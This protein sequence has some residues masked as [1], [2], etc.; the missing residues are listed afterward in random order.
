MASKADFDAVEWQT[1]IEGPAL[2]G[3]LVI[4]SQRGGTIRESMAMGHAYVDAL[5]Q[6]GGH[7]LLGEIAKKAPHLDPKEYSSGEDLR[8][9]GLEKIAEAVR[10]LESKAASDEVEAYRQFAL[11]VA[12][13]AAE[14][15]K[16]GGFLG[17]GGEAVT[18]KERTV[19]G[20][21]AT[22]LGTTPPENIE[23]TGA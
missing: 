14:A 5:R 18:E 17:V 12:Q 16:S 21:V 11:T 4:A 19:I 2:A 20:E 22:A 6:H 1:V 10:V 3:L 8:M 23:P 7:D 9:K 13:K 15:D